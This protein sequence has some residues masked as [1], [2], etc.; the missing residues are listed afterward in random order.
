MSVLDQ[1]KSNPNDDE[2]ENHNNTPRRTMPRARLDQDPEQSSDTSEMGEEEMNSEEALEV[3]SESLGLT[4]HRT[5]RSRITAPQGATRGN[6]SS[7]VTF[8]SDGASPLLKDGPL[9]PSTKQTPKPLPPPR[10]SSL[11][12]PSVN[13][14]S[15][16]IQAQNTEQLQTPRCRRPILMGLSPMLESPI[17]ISSGEEATAKIQDISAMNQSTTSSVIENEANLLLNGEMDPSDSMTHF[18]D[19]GNNPDNENISENN[20]PNLAITK[21]TR[22]RSITEIGGPNPLGKSTTP[23]RN[24]GNVYF[25]T[26]F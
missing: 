20:S 22:K 1:R 7:L 12:K 4:Q 16:N 5:D 15:T 19:G 9:L 14:D 11:K 2:D 3:L 18:L 26:D 6:S 23:M 10:V 21:L 13:N 25:E 24:C 17:E 8:T